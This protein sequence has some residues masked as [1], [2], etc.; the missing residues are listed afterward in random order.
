MLPWMSDSGDS[1]A[2]TSPLHYVISN[3]WHPDMSGRRKSGFEAVCGARVLP[4]WS[5]YDHAVETRARCAECDQYARD[6]ELP[7]SAV[8]VTPLSAGTTPHVTWTW[9]PDMAEQHSHWVHIEQAEERDVV[10][11]VCVAHCGELCTNTA[12]ARTM[13]LERCTRCAESTTRHVDPGA[14]RI[15]PFKEGGANG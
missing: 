10:A 7:R 4:L 9:L 8:S 6:H 3:T 5:A 1:R 15:V 2:S 12:E 13:S 11:E 14:V